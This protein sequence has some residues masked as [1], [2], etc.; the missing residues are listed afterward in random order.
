MDSLDKLYNGLDLEQKQLVMDFTKSH[1]RS[2]VAAFEIYT[3]FSYNP[4]LG[5]LDS[6]FTQLDTNVRL[7]FYGRL[8]QDLIDKTK[9]T[10]IGNP[11]PDFASNDEND[12]PVSLSSLKGKYVLLD[13]WASWCGP[14]AWKIQMLLK[15]IINSM[16][17]DLGSLV[18]HLM[19]QSLTG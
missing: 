7:S 19:I 17:K 3:N 16:I 1:P 11:A 5:Q 13:F 6:L 2:L 14:C 9:L 10:A 12:K 18:F 8:L 4:R 15:H